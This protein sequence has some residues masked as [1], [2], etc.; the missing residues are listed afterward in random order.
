MKKPSNSNPNHHTYQKGYLAEWLA[1][2]LLILK[3]YR[4]LATRY[5]THAGEID[6]IAKKRNT[7]TFIEV[8]YRKKKETL[9]QAISTHQHQRNQNAATYYLKTHKKYKAYTPRLDAIYIT[10]NR[11]PLHIKNL[12]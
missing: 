8:K 3:G 9:R 11:W 1:I 2:I 4:I 12:D 5:Q 7:I 6:I 10:P